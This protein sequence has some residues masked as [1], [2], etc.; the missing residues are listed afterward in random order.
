MKRDH[1]LDLLNDFLSSCSCLARF[2]EVHIVVNPAAGGFRLPKMMS[3]AIEELKRRKETRGGE[4]KPVQKN[5]Q[6]HLTTGPGDSGRI[7]GDV[8]HAC[9]EQCRLLFITTGGDGTGTE[10]AH[11]IKEY[12]IEN[13]EQQ[14]SNVLFRLPFGTGNDG[15]DA[16]TMSHAFEIFSGPCT[17][18]KI[19]LLKIGFPDGR[20]IYATNIA[21]FGLDAWV[22]DQT[23][24][25]KKVIPGSFYTIMVDVA[26]LFYERRVK[27]LP[28]RME[29][30]EPSGERKEY[31]ERLL[32]TAVGVTGSRTYG[33]G[34][35]VLPGGENV[36]TV[37]PMKLGRK[38]AF[39]DLLYKGEHRGTPEAGF[40]SARK[41]T[42]F[43]SGTLPFQY[44]G[45]VLWLHEKDF[46]VTLEVLEPCITVLVP[47]E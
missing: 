29:Y 3:G 44:D 21:S 23:N 41:I 35:R 24:R 38:F 28:I 40:F 31:E 16:R 47:E 13:P 7:T 36:C 15:L 8:L 25:L 17:T 42:F 12:E 30:T 22:T 5:I 10:A 39:K 27:V 11:A 4:G 43:Y 34:K 6:T 9:G 46:P 26:A 32:F 20:I 33:G 18:K 14:G 37:Y 1:F 19:G 45:E 2:D